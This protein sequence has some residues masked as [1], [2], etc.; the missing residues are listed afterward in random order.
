MK[1]EELLSYINLFRGK[2]NTGKLIIFVGA[3]VSRNVDGMPS[4]NQLIQE[5]AKAINYTKCETCNKKASECEKDCKFINDFS[6]DEYLKIPQ[7]VFNRDNEQY[8]RIL[9]ENIKQ[10]DV[11]APL[12]NAILDLNPAH[13][14]TTNYDKIIETCNNELLDNYDVIIYDK[15]LLNTQKN[16]YIIKMHG[17]IGDIET[18]VLKEADYLDYSQD[19]VLIEMFVKSLLTDHTILFLGYSL[20]DYNIKLIINW[21]NY[22]RIQ[23]KAIE[24]DT[25]FGYI[26]LDADK[27]NENDKAYFENNNIGVVNLRNMPLVPNIP[28]DLSNQI[29]QR[30]YSFLR[31]INDTSLE[32]I[33]G[34]KIFY[35]KAITF[36][37]QYNYINVKN[38]CKLLYIGRYS[39]EGRELVIFSEENYDS[40]NAFLS[41][42][43]KNAQV[44]QQ[45]FIDAGICSIK[46]VPLSSNRGNE[47][48]RFNNCILSLDSAYYQL[49]LNNQY[50][51]LDDAITKNS[52]T[53]V[54]ENNFYKAQIYGYTQQ[55]FDEYDTINTAELSV[56]N[57]IIYLFN[58]AA[59]QA[60]KTYS[61]NGEKIEKY[62]N[63]IAD[64]RQKDMY[65]SYLDILDGNNYKLLTLERSIKKLREQ[66]YGG[67]HSFLGTSS[68]NE[69]NKIQHIA[70]EQYMFYFKNTLFFNRFSDLKNILIIYAE[71][72]ICTNGQFV[73]KS[74]G[75][76]DYPNK[77]R[78][79]INTF[80]FDIL[81]K[82]L[83]IKEFNNL[84]QE[85]KVDKF[86]ADE[87]VV[88][89]IVDSFENIAFSMLDKNLFNH[90]LKAPHILINCATLLIHLPLSK[91]HEMKIA[92]T[93]NNLF[94][95]NQFLGF[96]F[97][98]QFP[99]FSTSL[100]II[101][102]LLNIVPLNND[103]C[104]VK[105]IINSSDFNQYIIKV[106]IYTLKSFLSKCID[107]SQLTECQSDINEFILSFETKKRITILRLFK[108]LLIDEE[109]INSHKDFLV[110][111]FSDLDSDD[112]FDFA[113]DDW[114]DI[115]PDNLKKLIDDAIN[116]YNQRKSTGMRTWPDY[117][118]AQLDIICILYITDKISDLRRLEQ[119][120]S[121]SV[122]LQFLIDSDNFDYTQVDFLNYMWEN[123]ARRERFMEKFVEHKD[124]LIPIIEKKIDMDTATE[125]ERKVLYGFLKD[126][127]KLL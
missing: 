48:I 89:F 34:E 58:L 74:T 65:T 4:W 99:D 101:E 38:I 83:S 30:L 79:K 8:N 39:V 94:N 2:T 63:G 123:I 86:L 125:F 108:K 64:I 81:T 22:I 57:K 103:F 110:L 33:F 14:I 118:K 72:I 21:I 1:N 31:V 26:T 35:N 68:L 62:I 15:D 90:I 66:Y 127:S 45:L 12:S 77:T 104:F 3:G 5:M 49:Y 60:Q 82:F 76:G 71:A 11:N 43:T 41:S 98:I 124:V 75:I 42:S 97:S 107:K 16:R 119:V 29:G 100:K 105:N 92:D 91:T 73:E 56:E 40:L 117:F 112:I 9:Q 114:L 84:L 102:R 61:Y 44:L 6:Q 37:A 106:N 54:F 85:Y 120:M 23:N 18:I 7:Y 51:V 70:I 88:D 46:L 87:N 115:S 28:S 78:Y 24:S 93:L 27:I 10:P 17:D 20:N 59:L 13:I 122:H 32:C 19:H 53:S 47:Y 121:E 36:M 50:S 126:Q 111:Y 116:M 67:N 25:K 96:F 80:D 52:S 69:F 109:I 55:M 95:H 113:F